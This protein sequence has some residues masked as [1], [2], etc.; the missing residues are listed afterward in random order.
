M[1]SN[2]DHNQHTELPP[3]DFT[4]IRKSDVAKYAAGV[5]AVTQSFKHVAREGIFRGTTSLLKL[6]QKNGFDCSSCAWPDPD[7]DRSSFEFC[8][9]GAKATASESTTRKISR[10]FFDDNSI[11]DIASQCDHWM[12]LQGRLTEPMVLREDSYTTSLYHGM[13]HLNWLLLNSTLFLTQSGIVL[14][15]W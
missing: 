2:S 10:S 8:E 11:T 5:P 13:K 14:H 7:D 3:E 1:T 6:N 15:I 12:E 9:N 4:G